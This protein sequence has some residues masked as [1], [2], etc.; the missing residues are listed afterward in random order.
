MNHEDSGLSRREVLFSAAALSG[1]AVLGGSIVTPRTAFA[2]DTKVELPTLPWEPASLAPNISVKT[3]EIHHGKHNKAYVDKVLELTKGKE[4]EGKSLET[5]V[6]AAHEAKDTALFNNSA[7][8][9]NHAFYWSSIKPGAKAPEGKLKEM[10]DAAGG[11]DKVKGELLEAGKGQFGSGWAWLV[12]DGGKLAVIK[13]S[14]AD[15]PLTQGKKALL[16]IDVWEH[17]YYLD[18]QNRRPDYVKAF[19]DNL[20][21]WEFAAANLAS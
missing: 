3:I 11:L 7:Q 16:T 14:N 5:I 1:A 2:G 20:L 13:T 6:K 17:A 10:L 4:L 21:N 12:E 8:A 18:Y 19:I 9:W 15:L